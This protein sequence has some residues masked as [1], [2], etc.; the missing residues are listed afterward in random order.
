MHAAL[1]IVL[2][3][4]KNGIRELKVRLFF[5]LQKRFPQDLFCKVRVS[6]GQMNINDIL[7]P[8]QIPLKKSKSWWI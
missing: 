7:K 6:G 2:I 8:I 4:T 5:T 1:R 3:L